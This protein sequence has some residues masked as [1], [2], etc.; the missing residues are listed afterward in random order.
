V[1]AIGNGTKHGEQSRSNLIEFKSAILVSA[2][3]LKE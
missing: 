1:I 3:Q 2:I